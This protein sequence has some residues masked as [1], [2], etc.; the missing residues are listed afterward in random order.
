MFVIIVS[1]R[2]CVD[3]AAIDRRPKNMWEL[4]DVRVFAVLSLGS[5]GLLSL[6]NDVD[7]SFPQVQANR[8]DYVRYLEFYTKFAR[9]YHLEYLI[10]MHR[11]SEKYPVFGIIRHFF[12]NRPDSWIS[13]ISR[14]IFGWNLISLNCWFFLMQMF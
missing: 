6:N 8:L 10:E 9:E 11:T 7:Q 2:V 3:T 4:R 12:T 13:L 1:S 5:M 14:N